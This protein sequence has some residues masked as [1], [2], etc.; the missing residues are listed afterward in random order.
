MTNF[1]KYFS[2]PEKLAEISIDNTEYY[3]KPPQYRIQVNWSSPGRVWKCLFQSGRSTVYETVQA[4]FIAWL[5]KEVPDG[6]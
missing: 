5:N 2:T 3:Y 6:D 1:E 4:E